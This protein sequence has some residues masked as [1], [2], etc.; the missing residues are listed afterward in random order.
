MYNENEFS[1]K[2]FIM[3]AILVVLFVFLLMWLF[4]MPNLKPVYDRLFVENMDTMKQAAKSYYT[5]ERLPKEVNKTVRMSLEEMLALKL[6]LPIADSDNKLCDT[7]ASYVEI[8]KTDTE[9]VVKTN[10]TC[11]SKSE[12]VIEH[13]GCY[14]LCDDEC[15]VKEEEPVKPQEQKKPTPK[16]PIVKPVV[17][18]TTLYQLKRNLYKGYTISKGEDTVLY[19][20]VKYGTETYFDGYDYS[21]PSGYSYRSGDTCYDY[22]TT[23]NYTCSNG[24]LEGSQCKIPQTTYSYSCPSGYSSSGSGSSMTCSKTVATGTSEVYQ[25]TASKTYIPTSTS[26]YRYESAGGYWTQDCNACASYFLYTYKI[27]KK[28]TNYSTSYANPVSTPS[29]TYKY[30]AASLTSTQTKITTPATVTPDYDYRTYVIDSKWTYNYHEYGYD[31]VDSKVISGKTK[32]V[33][34]PDWV[35]TLPSGYTKTETKTEYKWSSTK[36]QSGW[37]FTGNTKKVTK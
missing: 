12:Y 2:N 29:T 15:D 31:R 8:M 10:L 7:Q 37:T 1:I 32:K 14:E 26:T 34:T 18:T 35:V 21:C 5:V 13:M 20:H 36:T 3:K 27:Y 4:P 23:Y 30:E 11:S 25:G 33:Y 19:K 24:T 17:K 6:L 28:V 9:Y 22:K 16:K